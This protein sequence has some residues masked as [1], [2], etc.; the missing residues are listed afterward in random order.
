M[1][2]HRYVLYARSSFQF[3]QFD[4]IMVIQM[5]MFQF[6]SPVIIGYSFQFN[7]MMTIIMMFSVR[8]GI[9]IFHVLDHFDYDLCLHFIGF[10]L[11]E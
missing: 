1:H 8:S 6:S 2:M 7:S 11:H 4:K 9:F 10:Q 3:V 5:A